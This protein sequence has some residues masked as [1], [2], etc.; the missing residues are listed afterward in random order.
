MGHT[1]YYKTTNTKLLF[2]DHSVNFRFSLPKG[3]I[4]ETKNTHW[5]MTRKNFDHQA[6]KNP[7][8]HLNYCIFGQFFHTYIHTHSIVNHEMSQNPA[9]WKKGREMKCS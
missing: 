3:L 7:V 9:H 1:L 5:S 6:A 4:L 8:H 2:N